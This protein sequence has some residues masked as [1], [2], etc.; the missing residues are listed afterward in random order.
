MGMRRNVDRSVQPDAEPTRPRGMPREWQK[1][2]SER[3]ARYIAASR[4]DLNEHSIPDGAP[5]PSGPASRA[6]ASGSLRAAG[7]RGKAGAA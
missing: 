7:A 4:R 1:P 3:W 6:P 5:S 2:D